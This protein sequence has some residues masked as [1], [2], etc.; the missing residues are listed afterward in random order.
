[1][2]RLEIVDYDPR[3]PARF[4]TERA[5]IASAIGDTAL[6]IE[7]IGSTSIPGLA[8]KPII[9]ILVVVP[10]ITDDARFVPALEAAGY[11]LRVRE[12]DHRMFRTP[13]RDVHVHLFEQGSQEIIDYFDLR[14]WLRQDA[15]GRERYAAVKRDLAERPWRDMNDYADGE[16]AHRARHAAPGS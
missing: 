15:D 7:H 3:W 14:D 8:A 1:M 12:P 13:D 11:E 5:R 4:E 16:V 9:D 6:R 2:T 10:K